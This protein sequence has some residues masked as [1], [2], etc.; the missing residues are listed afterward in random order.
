MAIPGFSKAASFAI[1]IGEIKVLEQL[2][3]TGVAGKAT[4]S[5][6]ALAGSLATAIHGYGS[7][8]FRQF[9]VRARLLVGLQTRLFVEQ[10]LWELGGPFRLL[11]TGFNPV[12]K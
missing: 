10:V 1:T 8:R 5:F 2:L 7:R 9:W 11:V 6:E 3:K 4:A 12:T